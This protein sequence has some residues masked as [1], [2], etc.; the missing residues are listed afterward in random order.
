[1]AKTIREELFS[2][3]YDWDNLLL[4]YHD[5]KLGKKNRD[6]IKIFDEHWE[7]NLKTI[8]GSLINH[9]F[10]TSRY[11]SKLIYEPK[12]RR[13]YILPYNPDRIVQHALMNILTPYF[14]KWFI[15]DSYACI[16]GRGQLKA[17]QRTMYAVRRNKYCLK[18]DI[19]HFYPS[20]NQAILYEMMANKFK[21]ENLLYLIKDIIYSFPG[22]TNVPIGN[23]TSQWFG[24]YY[25]T[26]LD[27]YVKQELH[28][29]D[30][31]RYCDDFL[32]FSDDK[33]YLHECRKKIGEFIDRELKLTY[34]KSDVFNIKQ[35]IDFCGYRHFDNYILVRKSTSKREIK[36]IR[37]LPIKLENNLIS[38]EKALA[39]I[40]SIY[41]WIAHA[42]SYNLRKKMELDDVR[43]RVVAGI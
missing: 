12:E 3:V 11:N 15:A 35:G 9:T 1:M 37:E 24:N 31:I 6:A 43:K 14:E 32:L 22:G 42:N 19:H 40:D 5:S 17:S 39:Q 23:Y 21:D 33:K 8:Q 30:Y 2:K 10:T 36:K 34:S 20:I 7:E 38:T 13:I 29:K 18:C 41:G 28:I 27:N 25:L 4:A 26:I 16:K